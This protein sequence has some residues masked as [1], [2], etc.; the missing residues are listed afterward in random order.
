MA[1]VVL[2]HDR[3]VVLICSGADSSEVVDDWRDRGYVVEAVG[4]RH[5][6]AA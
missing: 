5:V 4:A 3:Q 6:T 2:D 1:W